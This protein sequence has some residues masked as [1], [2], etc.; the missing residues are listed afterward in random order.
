MKTKHLITAVAVLL[1]GA[2]VSSCCDKRLEYN[3]LKG[4]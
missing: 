2:A 4:G 1:A 3:G